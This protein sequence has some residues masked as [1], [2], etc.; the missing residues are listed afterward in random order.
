MV[1]QNFTT[2]EH[3]Y[4][5]ILGNG[6]ESTKENVLGEVGDSEVGWDDGDYPGVL[7]GWMQPVP[8]GVEGVVKGEKCN[9]VAQAVITLD[10]F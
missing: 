4:H 3:I 1:V 10:M 2:D 5:H 6:D 7:R 8:W 9:V